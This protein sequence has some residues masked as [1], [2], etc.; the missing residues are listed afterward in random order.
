MGAG[1][2]ARTRPEGAACGGPAELGILE[3]EAAFAGRL[4]ASFAGHGLRC[5]LYQTAGALLEGVA[6]RP[7]PRLVLLG[8]G[9]LAAQ[10]PVL[11]RLRE[12]SRVPCVL[13]AAGLDEAGGALA[14]DAGADDAADRSA[15]F[16]AVLARVRAVLR[17]ADWGGAEE[18]ATPA[19]AEAPAGTGLDGWRLL[20][21]R[22][23]LLFPNGR[24]CPLTTAEFDLVQVL[25]DRRGRPVS[26]D[27]IARTVFGR[28]F[29]PDDRAVDNL[30]LRLRRKLETA[31]DPRAIKTVRGAGY[32]FA[33][34]G[35]AAEDGRAAARTGG[36]DRGRPEEP[37]LFRAAPG[38]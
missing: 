24:E 6:A 18:A 23:Q 15:P 7:P 31:A 35:R 28:P 29:R 14:R 17:R 1:R 8:G 32:M 38:G 34:F 11:R 36:A 12:A 5:A 13:L 20:S 37:P 19:A 22:R 21:E 3:E 16:A 10:L 9:D 4:Q 26:R 33:G 30:V 25:V 2:A 27:A